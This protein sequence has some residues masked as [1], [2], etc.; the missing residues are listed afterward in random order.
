MTHRVGLQELRPER[1]LVAPPREPVD[2][3]DALAAFH[4][5]IRA[6]LLAARGLLSAPASPPRRAP[7]RS[8]GGTHAGPDAHLAAR[9]QTAGALVDFFGVVWPLHLCDEGDDLCD[10]L[11][12]GC[13]A[14]GT[15]ALVERV[16]TS[17]REAERAVEVVLPAWGLLAEQPARLEALRDVLARPTSEVARLLEGHLDL[18]ERELWPL[19]AERLGPRER[20][21]LLASFRAR[22]ARVLAAQP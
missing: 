2:A 7:A 22:R 15:A 18:A 17:Q 16:R 4:A 3:L 9:A 12:R 1:R 8:D 10:W 19:A 14:P 11:G 13:A 5:R 21:A 20:A 6:H